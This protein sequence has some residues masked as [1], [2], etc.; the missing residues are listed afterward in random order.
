MVDGHPLFTAGSAECYGDLF[1]WK[2]FFLCL[3]SPFPHI[4]NDSLR[5]TLSVRS[6]LLSHFEALVRSCPV[7]RPEPELLA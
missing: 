6:R 7:V 3:G 5:L 4:I 2:S 1:L